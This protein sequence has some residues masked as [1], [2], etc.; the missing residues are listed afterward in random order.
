MFCIS[1]PVTN[2]AYNVLHLTCVFIYEI[3]NRK[4]TFKPHYI[5]DLYFVKFSKEDNF[6]WLLLFMLLLMPH[7]FTQG[8]F[9]SRKVSNIIKSLSF[10]H[11]FCAQSEQRSPDLILISHL[12]QLFQMDTEA[13][14]SQLK[15]ILSPRVLRHITDG[16]CL[17]LFPDN[18]TISSER[19][20]DAI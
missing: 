20:K 9:Y 19:S 18:R 8:V 2:N 16:T 17:K 11:Q 3:S 13:L 4:N 15:D 6:L 12:L 7:C 5:L 1:F 10:I 14:P